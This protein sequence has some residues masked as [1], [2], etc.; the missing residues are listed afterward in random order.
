MKLHLPYIR[1]KVICFIAAAMAASCEVQDQWILEVPDAGSSSILQGSTPLPEGCKYAMEGIYRV[2]SGS[3]IFGDTVVLKNTGDR[4]SLFGKKNGSYFILETGSKGNDILM[5][6][7]WRQ[8]FNDN[9]GKARFLL[10]DAPEILSGDTTVS[11]ISFTG[12]TGNGNEPAAS[13]I[14]LELIGRFTSRLR[15]DQFIIG[16]HRGGG[17]TSDKLPVSENSVAMINYTKYFGSTGIEIDVRLTKDKIPVLYHDEDL[18][19][20]L[21]QKGPVFGKIGDFKYSQLLTLVTLIHGEKIPT[22]F[23]ALDAVMDNPNIKTV[24]LDMKDPE[25]IAIV[26]PIQLDYIDKAKKAGRDLNILIGLP[27]DDIYR[28]FQAYPGY[29]N[30]P[31]LCELAPEKVSAVNAR[32]W[33]FRWTQ[34]LMEQDVATM[35]SE[36][37]K[38]LVWTLDI[39]E[40]TE[41]YA[42]AG[43][44]DQAKRFDGILTNY[45][46]V[47]AYYH[48]VRHNY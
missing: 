7:Y 42:V 17:R 38:V 6:G 32:A 29:L 34:G 23:Q 26:V 22:L 46:T 21:I 10:S 31:S 2:S 16:A 35:H 43:G 12:L 40:F 3:D 27:A 9:T 1:I 28:S 41:I 19:I 4:I 14:G 20:R 33:G 25:A 48:Y 11:S 45:P 37:R 8:A 5:E 30:I 18:N 44:H 24:W 39:P 15:H 47:L 36:G 13:S